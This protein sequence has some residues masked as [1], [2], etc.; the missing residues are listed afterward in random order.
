MALDSQRSAERVIAANAHAL[1]QQQAREEQRARRADVI[2]PL[3]S[4]PT[5]DLPG[6]LPDMRKAPAVKEEARRLVLSVT[7]M[8]RGRMITI[9][10]EGRSLEAFCDMLDDRLGVAQ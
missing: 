5:E 10:S 7:I 9:S 6:D 1:R 4:L 3:A 2:T 8:H